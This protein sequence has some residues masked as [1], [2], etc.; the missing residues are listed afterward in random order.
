MSWTWILRKAKFQKPVSGK[1]EG[2]GLYILEP[3][4]E[5][6]EKGGEVSVSP[7]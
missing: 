2:Y 1:V 4:L 5:E 3:K 7:K 6:K